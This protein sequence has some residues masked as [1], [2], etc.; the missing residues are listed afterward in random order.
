MVLSADYRAPEPSR[1]GVGSV[2]K[3]LHCRVDDRRTR[4]SPI[5]DAF[6]KWYLSGLT[7]A[8]LDSDVCSRLTLTAVGF[9][10]LEP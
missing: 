9:I 2:L 5:E 8:R 3:C 10:S 7:E 4:A 6:A 1:E